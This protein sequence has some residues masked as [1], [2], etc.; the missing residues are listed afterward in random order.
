MLSVRCISHKVGMQSAGMIFQMRFRKTKGKIMK[1]KVCMR[2]L[3]IAAAAAVL[4]GSMP[5]SIYAEEEIISADTTAEELPET[6]NENT[7]NEMVEDS[8]G[9]ENT[10]NEDMTEETDEANGE[11]GSEAELDPQQAQIGDRSNSW[12]YSDGERIYE[13]VSGYSRAAAKAWSKVDG[14]FYNDQGQEIQGAI[15]KGIDVS[16][17]QGNI[18][19]NKVKATDV[20]YAII[21]CGY[22]NNE[23]SQDDT[24]WKINADACTQ[25]GIP[26]GA[27][28]YSYADSKEAAKSEAEHV[29]RLVKN[30]KLT[31]P[32]Y[33]DLE[34]NSVRNKLNSAQIAEVAKTFCDIIENAGYTVGIYANKDWFD[35]FLTDSYFDQADKWVAQYNSNCTY[36][37]EYTMWQCTADGTVDG[38]DSKI[39]L[40]MDFGT[41]ASVPEKVQDLKATSNV[42][43]V[44]VSWSRS[45]GA[46]GYLIYGKRGSNGEYGYIGMTGKLSYT[47]K[48]A[49]TD[50]YNF[51]WVYSYRKDASGNRIIS[52]KPDKY[53]YG[54][55]K[56]CAAV[57]NLKAS[58]VKKGV[59]L[60]WSKSDGAEGYLIY[61]KHGS[62]GEYGYIGMTGKLSYTDKNALSSEYNFYWIYPY[63]KNGSGKIVVGEKA[64]YVYGKAK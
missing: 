1:N 34:E 19:W 57:T 17:W 23:T 10:S 27:Y 4:T 45:K 51:Y 11:S 52:S 30:Y 35:N 32:I 42:G 9:D 7:E 61:G 8:A 24:Y 41:V 36:K 3:A 59:S 48:N 38:I 58:S 21:R 64:P 37:G 26:F 14:K 16:K 54:K 46:E 43:D 6:L 13:D 53:V 25:N 22:G 62:N 18:K 20:D 55:V 60:Q 12:R 49:L 40:N 2:C 63:F 5:A 15:A 50:E 39:D 56:K 28:I 33:L 47:D 29:L 44:K 31:Y